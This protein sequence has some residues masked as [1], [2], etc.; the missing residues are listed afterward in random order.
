MVLTEEH[1]SELPCQMTYP[2]G[3]FTPCLY[4]GLLYLV[5]VCGD[6]HFSVEVFCPETEKF[7]VLQVRLPEEMMIARSVAF[8]TEGELCLLTGKKQ[9]ARW[10]IELEGCFR[11][12]ETDT[13]CSSNQPPLLLDSKVLIACC[14]EVLQFNLKTYSFIK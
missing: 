1:W 8:V 12:S 13:Y 11:L 2:R 7:S 6:E 14:G 9:L 10:K 3:R 4:Q 5:S